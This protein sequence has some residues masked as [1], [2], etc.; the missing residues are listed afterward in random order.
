[1]MIELDHI[2]VLRIQPNDVIVL[3]AAVR[4]DVTTRVSICRAIRKK[5][6]HNECLVLDPDLDLEVA[7]RE[8]T[9]G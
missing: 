1:M 6:P 9:G 7:R 8:Q 5:F 3:K 4:L 2:D